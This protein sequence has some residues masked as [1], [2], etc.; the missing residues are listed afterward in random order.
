MSWNKTAM[1]ELIY[2]GT[3]VL[4]ADMLTDDIGIGWILNLVF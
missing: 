4:G 3:T 1:T 2:V